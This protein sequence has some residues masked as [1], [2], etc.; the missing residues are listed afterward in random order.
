M[1]SASCNLRGHVCETIMHAIRD[2]F[3]CRQF[4]Q[5]IVPSNLIDFFGMDLYAWI[6]LNLQDQV[7]VNKE[8]KDL[9][10]ITCHALWPWRNK[11][12]HIDKFKRPLEPVLHILKRKKDYDTVC[13]IM[14]NL[15]GVDQSKR[16]VG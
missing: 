14:C 13:R 3:S 4:W 11:E 6:K 7:G 10:A 5:S 1:G 15:E 8:W 16:L 9:W 12:Y 2:C